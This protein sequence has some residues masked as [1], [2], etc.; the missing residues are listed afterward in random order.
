M[1]FKPFVGYMPFRPYQTNQTDTNLKCVGI[2]QDN[3][4]HPYT[5]PYL[6]IHLSQTWSKTGWNRVLLPM[7][8]PSLMYKYR[9]QVNK[10]FSE[11]KVWNI[12]MP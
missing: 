2:M 4:C 12:G 6:V 5:L 7:A 9:L 1:R 10:K 8:S 3:L 11:L